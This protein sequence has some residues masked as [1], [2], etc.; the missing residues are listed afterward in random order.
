MKNS[1]GGAQLAQSVEHTTLDLRVVS[2]SPRLNVE[3]LLKILKT[4]IKKTKKL[5]QLNTK[6][7]KI[8]QLINGQGTWKNIFLKKT[9]IWPMVT[10]K[11][12][13]HHKSSGKCKSKPGDYHLIPVRMASIKTEEITKGLGGSLG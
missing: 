7:P 8:I 5:L 4:K 11:D 10:W 2:L 3:R 1:Y 6:N 13:Q 9:Y 12:A